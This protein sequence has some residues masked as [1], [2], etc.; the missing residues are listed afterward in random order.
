MPGATNERQPGS[1]AQ[2]VVFVTCSGGLHGHG[3]DASSKRAA[4]RRV[5]G[6]LG[7]EFAGDY[8]PA[9]AYAAAP[10]FVPDET[11]V[12]AH[13]SRLGI[14]D[15]HQLLGG[16]VPHPFVASKVITHRLADADAQAPSGWQPAFG[17]RVLDVVLPGYSAF[18]RAD[19]RR[20]GGL[21]LA[22]A[23]VRL[24]RPHGVGGRGQ[25]V[26][27]DTRELEAGLDA[28]DA[29]DPSEIGRDGLVLEYDLSDVKT[30]SV[31]QVLLGGMQITYCGTQRLT[32]ANDGSQVYG[33]SELFVARGDWDAL[34]KLA[35]APQTRLAI[36]QART[37]HEAAGSVFEGM[38]AS[39]SKKAGALIKY[40]RLLPHGHP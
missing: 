19:A 14:R 4:A 10:Y 24:K 22:S 3:H 36:D 28:I 13:A 26:V 8:D 20:A 27:R 30:L 33:G 16:V 25:T 2:P 6:L 37:Y 11:L 34:L 18:S 35:L 32:T 17:E 39:R 15:Q 1:A 23:P 40:A 7:L 31:G 29:I 5:A 21:L 38:F 9:A 12:L